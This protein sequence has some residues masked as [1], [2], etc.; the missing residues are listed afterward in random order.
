MAISGAGELWQGLL[1]CLSPLR[2]PGCDAESS[3]EPGF[4]GACAP[5]LEPPPSALQPPASVAAGFEYGGP[6]ADAI[7]RL[8]YG[9][10]TDLAP[11]LGKLLAT[12][13]LPYAGWVDCVIALPLFPRRL[14]ARGFN[15]SALLAGHAAR[16]LGVPLA[17][18][19]LCRTRD[20]AVQAGLTRELRISNVRGAFR[21]QPITARVLLIDDVHTTGATLASA[22]AALEAAGCPEV[23]ALALA[24]AA[25]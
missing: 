8:K 1:A 6:M 3:A 20:T 16:A 4:C 21:A 11:A 5:L 7:A 18:G 14:H 23:I 19:V 15:Q 12:A 13:A 9:G 24:A 17:N 2:C 22:A 10:R 25:G